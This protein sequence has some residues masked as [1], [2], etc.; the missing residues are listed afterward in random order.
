MRAVVYCRVS[1]DNQETEGTSIQTQ[2]DA[3][4]KYCKEKG[5]QV[6]KSYSE[7]FSGLT[8]ERPCLSELREMVRGLKIDRVV[9]FCLDRWV[10]DPTDG[11]ILQEE[12]ER[13]NVILEAVTECIENTELGKFISY[14]RGFASKL[15]AEKIKER[16]MRGKKA[17]LDQGKIP[18]GCGNGIYGYA[19]NKK[20]KTRVPVEYEVKIVKRIFNELANGKSYFAI[21]CSLNEH[22]IPSKSGGKWSTR[23][24][25]A[26]AGNPCYA[27]LTYYWQTRGSRKTKLIKQPKDKWVLLPDATPAIISKEQFDQVQEIRQQNRELKRARATHDYF[28]RGHVRCGYCGAPLVGSFMNHHY[29]YYHCRG[30]YSTIARQKICDARYIRADY[31]EGEVWGAIKKTLEQPDLVIAGIKEELNNEHHENNQGLSLVKEIDKLSKQ[32]KKY[33]SEEKRLIQLFRYGEINQ[34]SLLDEIN[35]L[36]AEKEADSLKMDILSKTKERI[37][38]LENAEIKLEEYCQKLKNQLDSASYQDKMDIL[39]ML[40]IKVVATPES[41]NIEGV[42]PLETTPSEPALASVVPTHHWTNMGIITCI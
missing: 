20:T 31:L 16:T 39:D 26:M 11:V 8:R 3:C 19:W 24:L 22:N 23:T 25:Y 10:R 4:L 12:L 30:A 17:F 14:T 41:I 7:T 5:Y 15:E 40:A 13:C 36:K 1:T 18:T 9:I 21:A 6:I 42:I 34:N 38:S 28:L 2:L 29:R 32:V 37:N 35:H 27:G 33:D